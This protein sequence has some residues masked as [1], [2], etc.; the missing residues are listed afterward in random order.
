MNSRKPWKKWAAEV[1]SEGDKAMKAKQWDTAKEWYTKSVEIISRTG[2]KGKIKN[3]TKE[4]Q[5][6][7]LQLAK[8]I[9][10]QGDDKYKAGAYQEAYELYDKSVSLAEASG[11]EGLVRNY[12]KERNKALKKME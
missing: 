10:N 1:N 11:D 4:M 2:N 12:S 6:A 8:E 7:Y 9:N 5:K 3:Y